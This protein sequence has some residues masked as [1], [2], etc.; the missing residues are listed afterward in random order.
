MHS[1]AILFDRPGQVSI[2]SLELEAPTSDDVVVDVAFSGV[3]SGTERLLWSGQMPQFPGMGYPLVP[4]YEA[5]GTVVDAGRDAGLVAGDMVF[6]PGAKCYREARSLFGASAKTLIAPGRRVTKIPSSLGVD[7]AALALAATAYHAISRGGR[8]ELIVGHGAL[9]RLLA[10]LAM[11]EAGTPPVVWE[12]AAD[13]QSGA[14][15]YS[16]VHPDHDRRHD[17]AAIYEV[18]GDVTLVNHLVTRLAKGGEIVLAGFYPGDV[19][20]AFAPAF[21]R[22]ARFVIAA[23]WQPDDMAAVIALVESGRLSLD[24]L[25]THTVP[26]S[27]AAGAYE[28]A[29]NDPR[30]LKLALDWRATS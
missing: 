20:F 23:E 30:C 6:V 28:T 17:Y 25:I 7:A 8:P 3:S 21:M 9:G 4:G 14:A 11:I 5:V 26:V 24:G 2:Q 10:R 13:R 1:T 22:E 18:S 29:F 15:G 19:S 12:T 16:V 27:D